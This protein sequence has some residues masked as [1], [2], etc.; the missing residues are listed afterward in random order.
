MTH[1]SRPPRKVGIL[2]GG[3]GLPFEI[4][5]ALA[6]RGEPYHV[7]GLDGFVS[8][9]IAG[10]PHTRVGLG[11]LGRLLRAFREA[12]CTDLVI[13]G[14]LV[15]PDVTK[16]RLDFGALRH[17]PSWLALTRGGDDSLLRKVVRFFEG[18]G[19]RVR[20]AGDI[21]PELL[22]PPGMIAGPA[23][24]AD[25]C[26]I[27][28]NG[29]AALQGL[30]PFDMGQ[31]LVI[32]RPGVLAF[33][34]GAGTARMLERMATTHERYSD[35]CLV[36][37]AKAGQELRV[38]TP[39]IGAQT[40]AQAVAAGIR[41]IGVGAGTTL[42]AEREKLVAAAEKAGV[43]VCGIQSTDAPSQ[44]PAVPALDPMSDLAGAL[45]AGQRDDA[46]TGWQLTLAA[47]AKA[48]VHATDIAAVV[49]NGHVMVLDCDAIASG[50]LAQRIGVLPRGWGL[51][52]F[53]RRRG[54][55]VIRTHEP[56]VLEAVGPA[57]IAAAHTARLAA[58]LAI[59]VP[60]QR[61]GRALEPAVI[62]SLHRLCETARAT[63]LKAAALQADV[64]HRW[65]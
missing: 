62:S 15:R 44:S 29:V 49:R 20:G 40:I 5:D 50:R 65:E 7:V 53:R 3:G 9:A 52:V 22:A 41:V 57:L 33:E 19:F 1:E 8:D 2:A 4:A 32:A 37:L 21:V 25:L 17:A 16:L 39:T 38:D 36:K 31:A 47:F 11:E 26:A 14:T 13:I 54:V 6:V 55:L 24:A 12:G 10:H 64:L 48:A 23:L 28:D 46:R 34:D 42:L 51:D 59:A 27:I 43:T 35:A 61:P 30:S 63:G 45:T 60:R 58:L 18:Q 56:Q